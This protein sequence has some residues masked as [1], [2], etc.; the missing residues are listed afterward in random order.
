[1]D[2]PSTDFAPWLAAWRLIPD[3]PAFET[4]YAGNRLLPARRDGAPAILKLARDPEER[5]GAALMA[6]WTG[7]GAARVLEMEGD[8]L[9]LE[10]L[11]GPRSLA[12]MARG[13]EDDA[14]SRILCEVADRLHA[15][16]AAPPPDELL[17]LRPWLRA[18]GPGAAAHG[19]AV[20]Q[21]AA[22]AER[23]LAEDAEPCV[24]HGDLHHANVLD[25]GLRG[26]L[27]ID[28]KGITGPR[29]YDYANILCNPDAETALAPGR[30]DRQIAVV[31]EAARLAPR[32]LV[33]WL[34]VH[35]AISGVWCVQD[36]FDPGPAFALADLAQAR[37][38]R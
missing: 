37:L 8:A 27:A 19:G 18:L 10:R 35:A 34:L 28:P 16:R 13:G 31:A 3:G 12:D 11:E 30:L 14:A 38:G 23:L 17:P 15:P 24:L 2:G 33:E 7:E 9:L 21:A 22:L 6:W 1:M 29:G 4:G 26:W 5:R 32:R 25:G 36:G 20:A